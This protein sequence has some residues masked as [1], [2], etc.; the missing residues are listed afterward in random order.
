MSKEEIIE[1]MKKET[2]DIVREQLKS[3][4][5]LKQ[6]DKKNL[7][8]KVIDTLDEVMKNEDN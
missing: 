3:D 4:L 5:V 8:K 7:S 6:T 2:E 1:K